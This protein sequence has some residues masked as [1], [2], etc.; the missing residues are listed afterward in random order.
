MSRFELHH[1]GQVGLQRALRSWSRGDK[2]NHGYRGDAFAPHIV[3]AIAE[4]ATAKALGRFWAASVDTF[5]GEP[6]VSGDVEVRWS[7]T[8]KLIIRNQDIVRHPVSRYVLVTGRGDTYTIHGWATPKE[9]E[10]PEWMRAPGNRPPA[11]FV[12]VDHLHDISTI[13]AT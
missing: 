13:R 7:S 1:A 4:Y 12:P 6:D 10:N 9:A 2:D 5:T 11:Y 3:G 8:G